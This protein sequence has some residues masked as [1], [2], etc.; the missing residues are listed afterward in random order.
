MTIYPFGNSEAQLGLF[1]NDFEPLDIR[2]KDAAAQ[3]GEAV[4]AAAR[5]LA[6]GAERKPFHE[7]ARGKLVEIFVHGAG[8]ESVL[9][10]RLAGDL[11]HDGVAMAIPGGKGQKD[12]EGGRGKGKIGLQAVVH[13]RKQ[14]YRNP[15]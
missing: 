6:R 5:I 7:A 4:V 11:L 9:A 10:R 3:I 15:V 14:I 1:H 12:V 2:G 8:A 13:G